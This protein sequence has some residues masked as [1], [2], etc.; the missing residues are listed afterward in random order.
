MPTIQENID[1]LRKIIKEYQKDKDEATVFHFDVA[2][3]FVDALDSQFKKIDGVE[4][5]LLKSEI[6]ERDDTIQTLQDSNNEYDD[7]TE[8]NLG[9]GYIRFATN[10]LIYQERFDNL[11]RQLGVKFVRS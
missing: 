5:M 1:E 8:Y 3:E 6:A 7:V 11:L 2:L 9:L 4:I 10:S